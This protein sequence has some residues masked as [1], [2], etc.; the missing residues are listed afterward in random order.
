MSD[1]SAP[2]LFLRVGVSL[3]L[4]LALVWVAA[5]VLRKRGAGLSRKDPSSIDVIARRSVGRRSNLLMV[6]IG[7]RSLLVG[8]TDQQISLVADLSGESADRPAVGPVAAITVDEL[9]GPTPDDDS[10]A[11]DG[12]VD[13]FDLTDALEVPMH[14]RAAEPTRANVLTSLRELTVRRT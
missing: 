8:V 10:V 2:L 5:R 14:Q 12:A 11:D 9:D 7:G 1:A 4:V 3:S 6:E 13:T